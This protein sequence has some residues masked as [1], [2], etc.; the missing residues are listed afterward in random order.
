MIKLLVTSIGSLVGQNLLDVIDVRADDIRVVG[1]TTLASIPLHRCERAYLV[2]ATERPPSAFSRRLLEIIEREQP[3]LIIPT[4]DRDV[5][6]LAELAAGQPQFVARIPCGSADTAR[7][8]ED[9]WRSYLFARDHGLVFAESAIPDSKSGH[10]GVHQ[11][12][13]KAGFPLV[14]K[15]RL[16]FASRRVL[17]LRNTEQLQAVLADEDLLVQRY[18]GRADTLDTFQN[19]VLQRG[20]PLFYSLEQDKYS[21]QTY[22]FRDGGAGPVCCTLNRMEKGLSVAVEQLS[23]ERLTGLGNDWAGALAAAGWRGPLN[24]QC[25]QDSGG[26]FVAFELNGR[27][28]GATAARYYLGHD[29]LGTL[30]QDRLGYQTSPNRAVTN[31]LPFKYYHTL[32]VSRADVEVLTRCHVWDRPA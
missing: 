6:V 4:R 27:F 5:T 10:Q 30:L 28:T 11:L 13:E 1:T 3:D 14:A 23:D 9:K 25:Q 26:D 8:L 18:L 32:G 29:E 15:P 31:Q 20:Q 24:I 16:G 22:V 21:V 7:L 19:D 2:P 17:L 12:V